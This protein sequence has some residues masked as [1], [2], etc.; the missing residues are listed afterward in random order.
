MM[1]FTP[2][3]KPILN[4]SC[5]VSFVIGKTRAPFNTGE[6]LMKPATLKITEII[7]GKKTIK[8]IKQ[9]PLLNDV[10]TLRTAK[11][12]CNIV[13]QV[14]TEIKENPL[15]ISLQLDESTD[16]SN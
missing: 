15:R 12:S 11:M 13:D 4:A 10:V 3:E 8:K 9:V 14:V 1:G 5:E 2:P 6:T 16:V 7:L